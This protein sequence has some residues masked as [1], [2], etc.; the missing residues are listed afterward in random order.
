VILL[1]LF[2]PV[3]DGWEFRT[4]QRGM[5]GALG[6]IPVIVLSGARDAKMRAEELAVS[7]ALAKP[8]E[9]ADVLAA[10]GRVHHP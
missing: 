6:R 7:E 5:P 10:V 9:I 3:M 4:R 8:F 1:D 2:M